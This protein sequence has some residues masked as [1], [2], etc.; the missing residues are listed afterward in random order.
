MGRLSGSEYLIGIPVK[1]LT[2][3][4]IKKQINHFKKKII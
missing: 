1:N 2:T 4:T 3:L